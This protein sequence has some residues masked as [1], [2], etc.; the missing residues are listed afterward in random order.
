MSV[1]PGDMVLLPEYG[2]NKI[3]LDDKEYHLYRD[4]DLLGVLDK[5]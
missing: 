4:S 3:K 5:K 1:K 2:G